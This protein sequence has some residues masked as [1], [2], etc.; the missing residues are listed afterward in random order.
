MKAKRRAYTKAEGVPVTP[1]QCRSRFVASTRNSNGLRIHPEGAPEPLTH[2]DQTGTLCNV[3]YKAACV[4][5]YSLR[6]HCTTNPAGANMLYIC[7]KTSG[8]KPR[9]S[10]TQTLTWNTQDR[11]NF[12]SPRCT[13]LWCGDNTRTLGLGR[14]NPGKGPELLP[15]PGNSFCT[16]ALAFSNMRDRDLGRLNGRSLHN[17]DNANNHSTSNTGE[18]NETHAPD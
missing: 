15:F 16:T 11:N 18:S 7:K 13:C 10:R 12:A 17:L 3:T 8:A 4:E 2:R 6:R 1:A 14:N 5:S 9:T